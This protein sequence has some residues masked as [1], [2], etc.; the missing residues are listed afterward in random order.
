MKKLFLIIALL[1]GAIFAGTFEYKVRVGD[2]LQLGGSTTPVTIPYTLAVTSNMT[3][4]GTFAVTKTLATT[5]TFSPLGGIVY[6][7]EKKTASTSNTASIDPAKYCTLITSA[8]NKIYTLADGSYLGQMKKVILIVDGG[9]ITL[10]PANL[11]NGTS[12]TFADA[13]DSVELLWDGTDWVIAFASGMA[14]VP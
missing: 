5:G 12:L 9:T 2:T 3:V 8:T 7:Y 13:L 1:M 6:S 14:I 4:G 11:A 10:T